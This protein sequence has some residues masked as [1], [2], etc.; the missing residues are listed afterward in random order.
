M[1]VK[2]KIIQLLCLVSAVALVSGIPVYWPAEA[3]Q[4]ANA[5]TTVTD[6]ISFYNVPSDHKLEAHLDYADGRTEKIQYPSALCAQGAEITKDL[7]LYGV[8]FVAEGC[9]ATIFQNLNLRWMGDCLFELEHDPDV[10]MVARGPYGEAV[11][12]DG[13]Y[14]AGALQLT[15]LPA[16]T[17]SLSATMVY[18][19]PQGIV[20]TGNV[21]FTFH[22]PQPG[23]GQAQTPTATTLPP[24]VVTPTPTLP[25]TAVTATPT[26]PSTAVT[27]TPTLPA[28][29][30][31]ATETPTATPKTTGEPPTPTSTIVP[32][33]A[34]EPP[35]GLGLAGEPSASNGTVYLPVILR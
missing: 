31:T 2:S 30:V 15:N 34:V 13:H 19:N 26:L 7:N 18:T 11:V 17:T 22:A 24:T 23:C 1:L 4:A 28:T 12:A 9:G 14:P 10:H 32:T 29:A 8:K 21:E 16:D 25:S 20:Q 35:T 3:A 33:S 5:Q 6:R 27:A